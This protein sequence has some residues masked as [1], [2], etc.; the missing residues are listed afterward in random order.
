MKERCRRNA[1]TVVMVCSFGCRD[2]GV[3]GTTR[4]WAYYL[5]NKQ[6]S[7]KEANDWLFGRELDYTT[8]VR[9][10]F[11]EIMAGD[12]MSPYDRLCGR[13]VDGT[14]VK[15]PE[16]TI[17]DGGV[18]DIVTVPPERKPSGRKLRVGLHRD[19]G[20]VF[21]EILRPG[22]YEDLSFEEVENLVK[23]IDFPRVAIEGMEDPV[24]TDD[25][26]C[27]AERMTEDWGESE[28]GT[29]PIEFVTGAFNRVLA[30]GAPQPVI[31][32]GV[33]FNAP[34]G[35]FIKIETIEDDLVYD[36]R[37]KIFMESIGKELGK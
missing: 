24:V 18:I 1:V 2:V 35:Q 37:T 30:N 17:L 8:L 20:V 6:V 23:T 34:D 7:R 14:L 9:K 29:A 15:P 32:E 28:D 10:F 25:P 21:E 19:G 12:A 36:E 27:L 5:F 3:Y 11:H 33:L 22:M 13:E 26:L 16:T 31:I 4:F